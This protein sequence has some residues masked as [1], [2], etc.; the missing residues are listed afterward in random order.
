MKK[1]RARPAPPG[2]VGRLGGRVVGSGAALAM[3]GGWLTAG[4]PFVIV[5][6]LPP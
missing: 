6:C 4:L 3:A 2:G 1:M 5:C